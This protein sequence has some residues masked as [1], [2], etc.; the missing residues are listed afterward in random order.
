MPLPFRFVP[1]GFGKS[2]KRGFRIIYELC[3][4]S[5]SKEPLSSGVG[6]T[7]RCPES[8]RPDARCPASL[9]HPCL[10]RAGGL[11]LGPGS[12]H[13]RL[14]RQCRRGLHRHPAGSAGQRRRVRQADRA[15]ALDPLGR[16]RPIGAGAQRRGRRLPDRIWRA[17][18]DLRARDLDRGNRLLVCRPRRQAG[19]RARHRPHQQR[20]P[21]PRRTA[22]EAVAARSADRRTQPH[23]SGRRAGGNDRGNRALPLVLRLHADRHRSSG[24]RQRRLRLRRRRRR[25]RR[26]RKTH[27]RAA[28]RRRRARPVL[29]Q[30]V[31]PDPAELHRRRHQY[32]GRALPGRHSRRGG[33]DQI[34]PGLGDGLD[35]RDQH[36]ALRPQRR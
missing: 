36:A 26:S 19:A 5:D 30:Q 35:R 13:H 4:A 3:L 28:A 22:D 10:A 31:R 11:R 9:Q 14:E 25:D 34:R 21:R 2:V 1:A 32:R 6:I 27:P 29:R 7:R 8:R 12:R 24:A 17:G 23:A 20:A 16:A 33:A 15:V 18:R